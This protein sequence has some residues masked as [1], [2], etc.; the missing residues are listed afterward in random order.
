MEESSKCHLRRRGL[1]KMLTREVRDNVW[2]VGW[3]CLA[4]V[5]LCYVV[6]RG[7]VSCWV[8]LGVLGVLGC[9][10]GWGSPHPHCFPSIGMRLIIFDRNSQ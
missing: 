9:V 2:V 6:L 7:V 8:V 4:C 10:D 5:V 1:P 3:L